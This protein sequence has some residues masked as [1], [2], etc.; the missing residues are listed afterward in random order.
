MTQPDREDRGLSPDEWKLLGGRALGAAKIMLQ[1]VPTPSCGSAGSRQCV[2]C[3]RRAC[4]VEP[5]RRLRAGISVSVARARLPKW[6]P[7]KPTPV[8]SRRQHLMKLGY[9]AVDRDGQAR[10][11]RANATESRST[12]TA[13]EM[14]EADRSQGQVEL[15]HLC[16]VLGEKYTQDR[17]VHHLRTRRRATAD[18]R[19]GRLYRSGQ[20]LSHA[21]R[22]TWGSRCGDGLARVSSTSSDRSRQGATCASQP[23][24]RRS[25]I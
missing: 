6:H 2:S 1:G 3:S 9:R 11:R 17:V 21:P 19:F 23:T 15:R 4:S 25:A 8:A 22:R 12:P 7:R 14:V 20:P 5:P 18:G 10:R 24:R 16:E 13:S